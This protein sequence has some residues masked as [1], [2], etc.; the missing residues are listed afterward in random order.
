MKIRVFALVSACLS[1][2]Y[3]AIPAAAQPTTDTGI[4]VRDYVLTI[5]EDHPALGQARADLD[6]AQAIARGQSQP[7][8]NP[9]I[10]FEYEDA[11]S[12]TKGVGVSQALDLSGKRR[13]RAGVAAADTTAAAA[14]YDIVRKALLADILTALSNYQMASETLRVSQQRVKL[15]QDF[16]DIAQ[17]RRQ[18]GDLPQSEL[19]TARLALAEAQA[20]ASAASLDFSEADQALQALTG[21]LP[22]PPPPLPGIPTQASPSLA[23][24]TMEELPELR[25]AAATK[26]SAQSGIRVAKRNRIPDPTVGLRFGEEREPNPLGGMDSTTLFGIRLSVPIP[27]LNT[28]SAEVDAAKSDLIAAEQGYQEIYRKVQAR[29][30]A[31]RGRYQTASEAWQSWASG[32]AESLESQRA[33]LQ[34]LWD[35]GEIGAVDYIIQLNQTFATETAGIELKSRL[36]TT[37]FEWLDASA[38]ISEW[39]ENIK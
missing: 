33:L 18:S 35:A 38:S 5:L 26:A 39:V 25:L 31:S 16:L 20:A 12:E 34:K 32:G 6:A 15:N 23:A 22:A 9:E 13:A 28:Y 8:Y 19:L 14:R 7:L 17:R 10:E 2:L 3:L 21:P 37:W 1:Y 4:A 30:A 36:W 11:A 29:L 27:V 24:I